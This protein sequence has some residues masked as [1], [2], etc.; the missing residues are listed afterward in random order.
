MADTTASSGTLVCLLGNARGGSSTWDSLYKNLLE[1]NRADLALLLGAS[2]F[3]PPPAR[4]ALR[5]SDS[6]AESLWRGSSNHSMKTVISLLRR[7]NRA[8]EAGYI[9]LPARQVCG[10]SFACGKGGFSLTT[11]SREARQVR[12]RAHMSRGV[13]PRRLRPRYVWEVEEYRDW[14]VALDSMGGNGA[15]RRTHRRQRDDTQAGRDAY[16]SSVGG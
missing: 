11:Q 6:V 8:A 10:C 7:S 2:A 12:P 16:Q 14:A 9:S 1:P 15:W 5:L 3:D 13:P 4:V